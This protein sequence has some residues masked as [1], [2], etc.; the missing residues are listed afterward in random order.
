[1]IAIEKDYP[2]WRSAPWGGA[3]ND[4]KIVIGG[5]DLSDAAF[6]WLFAPAEG[7]AATFTLTEQMDGVTQGVLA[8]YF[9]EYMHP[10][11]GALVPG[12]ATEIVPLIVEATFETD[13][14]NALFDGANPLTLFHQ[15]YIT[16]DGG[17][18]Y[19]ERFGNLT[20]RQGVP[21]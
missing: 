14:V 13:P 7:E 21:N 3:G 9:A 15:L 19:V 11:S 17:A 18:Q 8:T 12:G 1:M 10:T 4:V 20:I 6:A 16:P 2:A 5:E